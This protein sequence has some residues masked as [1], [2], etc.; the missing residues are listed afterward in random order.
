M[1]NFI[2]G[3]ISITIGTIMISSVFISAVKGANQTA[4]CFNETS[5]KQE[6]ACAWSGSEIALWGLLT[7]V[8]IAGILYGVLSVFGIV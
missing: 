7:I 2:M 4:W 5:G 8:G 6:V 3:M 1:A